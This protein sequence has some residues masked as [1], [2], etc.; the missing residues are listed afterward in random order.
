MRI[1][2]LK[3]RAR[4]PNWPHV[5]AA[6]TTVALFFVGLLLLSSWAWLA[7]PA[8]W[9]RWQRQRIRQQPFAAHWRPLLRKRWPAFAQLPADIQLQLKKH[10]QV[11]L[12]EKPFIGCAG[13]VVT[14]EMRVLVAMQAAL[15]LLHRPAAA[16]AGLREVL[17]YPGAFV[18]DRTVPDAT[19]VA[20][21]ER[22]ARVG[23]S[24]QS[25]RVVLSWADVVAGAANPHDGH[26]VVIHEFAH[27][28]DQETGAAN[29]APWLGA[30]TQPYARWAA[31]MGA[32]FAALRERLLATNTKPSELFDAYAATDAAEFFAVSSELFF[33]KPQA[34]AQKHPALFAELAAYYRSDPRLWF[35]SSGA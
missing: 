21:Q 14:D 34:L 24:W 5:N 10:A 4:V 8:W 7:G 25:G 15:L 12:A 6:D 26:N 9:R 28:L 11:L 13:L 30:G 2:A 18:V 31:V 1:G 29:G 23:E 33:E 32:E 19:G 35:E 20:H 16:F 3:V 17:L 27:Q 22:H